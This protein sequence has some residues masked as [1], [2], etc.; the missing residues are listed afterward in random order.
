MRKIAES[1]LEAARG[2]LGSQKQNWQKYSQNYKVEAQSVVGDVML[3]DDPP[4]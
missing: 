3:K 4:E 1:G 2:L